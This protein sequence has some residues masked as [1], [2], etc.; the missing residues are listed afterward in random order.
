MFKYINHFLTSW[1]EIEHISIWINLLAHCFQ[2]S[3][4]YGIKFDQQTLNDIVPS[5]DA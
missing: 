3:K 5:A 4:L 1:M 2:Q